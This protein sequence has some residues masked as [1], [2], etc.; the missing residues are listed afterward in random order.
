MKDF[1]SIPSEYYKPMAG[2]IHQ[3]EQDGMITTHN[4]SGTPE[5][6][7]SLLPPDLNFAFAELV[8][9]D[10]QIDGGKKDLRINQH[11]QSQC[12]QV[13]EKIQD[14]VSQRRTWDFLSDVKLN[15]FNILVGNILCQ[16]YSKINLE[17][18]KIRSRA[19]LKPD[20][21]F[22]FLV[23]TYH[24]EKGMKLKERRVVQIAVVA[25]NLAGVSI[26][27]PVEV[28]LE[29]TLDVAIDRM[30]YQLRGVSLESSKGRDDPR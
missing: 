16:L 14:A 7:Q 18:I 28:G 20:N 19:K 2:L 13:I 29:C 11:Y 8:R 30:D 9:N 23:E 10:S 12:S 17:E 26:S 6:W 15:D 27:N 3:L 22:Y 25:G 24:F 1:M 5:G 21:V 4:E